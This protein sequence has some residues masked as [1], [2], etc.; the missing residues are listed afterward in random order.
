[1]I[2]LASPLFCVFMILSLLV[3]ESRAAPDNAR[4]DSRL[5]LF[6]D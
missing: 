3:V 2:S 6:G 1:M 4:D 5:F